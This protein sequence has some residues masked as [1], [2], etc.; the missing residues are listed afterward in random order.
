MCILVRS[1]TFVE[2]LVCSDAPVRVQGVYSTDFI[3][4]HTSIL[5]LKKDRK[6]SPLRAPAMLV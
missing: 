5:N 6:G 3:L 2:E 4:L 1:P